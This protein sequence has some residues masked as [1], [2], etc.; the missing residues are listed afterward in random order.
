MIDPRSPCIIGI[1]RKTWRTSPAPEPLTMWAAMARQA[2][3]DS[4]ASSILS[5][6]DAIHLVHCMS[7]S[8]DDAPQRLAEA[9]SVAP[10]F[11][12]TSVLAGTAGQRM[13][14]SAA[15]RMLRGD[16]EVA[17]VVGGE[18][19]HT[20][21]QILASGATPR[22]SNPTPDPSHSPIDL[23][24]WISPTEWAH[25]VIQPTV[26]FAALDTARRA[27]AGMKP[28][29]Y[30]AVEGQLLSR[31]TAVAASNEHA[32]FPIQREPAVITTA[33]DSNR[34]ISSPYTK[35][36]VA[37]MDVDMAAALLMTTHR[38]AD[39]LGIPPD[40]RVYLRGWSFGRDATHLAGRGASLSIT[41][42]G[43]R[44]TRCTLPSWNRD[45]R[46]RA[47]RPVQLFR[48]VGALRDR[49]ARHRSAWR[50]RPH[51]HRRTALSRWTGQ[52][53]HHACNC[54][55]CPSPSRALWVVRPRL[56]RGHAHDETR[57][58][59]VRVRSGRAETA[60]LPGSA[61]QDRRRPPP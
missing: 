58:G 22:W 11:T 51:R 35:Y 39:D 4:G 14:N 18:A 28:Q 10:R 21:R 25:D 27:H 60:R 17:L 3:D 19:L 57:V 9:L 20:K 7:W 5:S 23:D 30:A 26:T 53:L 40:H 42:D 24:D 48:I 47:P 32:W 44:L 46:R 12:E 52:Q 2:V 34:M 37:I 31:L 38:K 41:G 61:E 33:T 55:D 59:R 36:M 13:V 50:S 45:R 6:V 1:A 8:Y 49:R 29:D 56:R 43:D 54:R 15:E 16:S